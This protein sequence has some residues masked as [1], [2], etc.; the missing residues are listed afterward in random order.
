M[1]S[2][3]PRRKRI[4]KQFNWKVIDK[5]KTCNYFYNKLEEV[6]HLSFTLIWFLQK[7]LS[8]GYAVELEI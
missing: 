4:R 8:A 7:K 1:S 5:E 2:S 3:H 6:V